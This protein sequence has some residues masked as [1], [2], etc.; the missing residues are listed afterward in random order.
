MTSVRQRPIDFLELV[1]RSRRGRLK[2]YVGSAPGV[3]KTYRMLEEARSLRL[4]GVDVAL[5]FVEAHG[6][7]EIAALAGELPLVPRRLI[8][9]RGVTVEDMDLA[10][11]LR[12]KPQVAIVDELAHTNPPGSRNARRYQDVTT[13]LDAGISVIAAFNV[14]HL[15]SLN[16]LVERLTGLKVHDTVPDT[17]VKKADQVVNIDLSVEDL[18]DRLHAGAIYPPER[19][20]WA[21][22]HVFR[23]ECLASLRE[24]A[25]RE[26]AETLD[27]REALAPPRPTQVSGRVMVC[28]SSLSPRALT[29]LRR[30]SRFAGRLATDWFVVYVETPG[31][32]PERIRPEVQRVIVANVEK[33]RE[34]GAEV[35]RLKARDAVSALLDFARSHGVATILAGRS[36]RPPWSRLLRR[37]PVDRLFDEAVD[38][39]LYVVAEEDEEAPR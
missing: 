31:E 1:E 33:A 12:R 38:V 27:R 13:L 37:S 18:L 7:A 17:F 10:A 26:V 9:H 20:P 19:V 36:R 21:L 22:E 15:E 28:L 35:V 34:L 2:L 5:A 25:L 23:R 39:D 14:Q 29:L 16:D 32:A 4:R 30:G 3:G 8:E 24:L 11:V 6:R